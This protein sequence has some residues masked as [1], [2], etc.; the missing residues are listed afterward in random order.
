MVQIMQSRGT[1]EVAF[2]YHIPLGEIEVHVFDQQSAGV[3]NCLGV[4]ALKDIIVSLDVN[5]KK[6]VIR[7]KGLPDATPLN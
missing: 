2:L 7:R 1:G 4:K 5:Q 3:T 6:A